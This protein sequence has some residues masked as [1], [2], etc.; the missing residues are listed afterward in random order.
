MKNKWVLIIAV[1]GITL[2][3]LFGAGVRNYAPVASD[4]AYVIEEDTELIVS[5]PGILGNDNDEDMN[6]GRDIPNWSVHPPSY[7]FNATM[8]SVLIFDG[9]E[10]VDSNDILA[11][12]VG[13]ECRGVAQPTFFPVNGRYTVNLMNYANTNGETM[14]FKAYDASEDKVYS[15]AGYSYTFTANEM[16]GNDMVPLEMN[17]F[18]MSA[19]LESDAEYGELTL[20]SDGSFNYIPIEN[21][22]GLDSFTYVAFDGIDYSN[23]ASVNITINS[24]NDAPWISTSDI[25]F[26]ED[27]ELNLSFTDFIGDVDGDQLSLSVEGNSQIS[28]IVNEFD[29]LF[30]TIT[31]NW[32]GSEDVTF[33]VSDGIDETSEIIIVNV[34][35]V[36]D[37]PVAEDD[38][39]EIDE[40]NYFQV[41]S[42]GVL[43]NDF[44]VDFLIREIPNWSVHAPN[45]E[46][47]STFTSVL[48]FDGEESAD[49]NDILAVFVG[50]E[51]RGVAQ[52]TYFPITDRFT[53][54]MMIYANTNGETMTFKAYDS[55]E[56]IV[57]SV[58]GYSY[59][60]TANDNIG[61]DMNPI[62]LNCY[63]LAVELYSDVQNGNLNLDSDGSFVYTPSLNYFGSDSFSYR[64]FD[65]TDY[66]GIASVEIVINPVN[67]APWVS[68]SDINFDEDTELNLNF[69]NL[70]G[71]VDGDQLSLSVEGNSQISIVVNEFDVLFG[72]ITENWFGSEDVTFI[73]SDGVFETTEDVVINVLPVNDAPTG[74]SDY[75]EI[76]EDIT[77]EIESPGVL[78]NDYDI[79][80]L[81]REI[82]NWSVH[83]P[84]FEFNSTFTS[85]LTFD[86]EESADENDILAVF[87]GEECRGVAQPTYFPITDRFTVNMMIYANT[88]GETMTFKAYDS[89]E[90]IVYSVGGY[91]YEFTANDNIG[92]DMNPIEL[93]CYSLSV[94]LYSDV[95]NGNLI[96]DSD[97]SFVYTPSINYF[98][99]D[100]FS[101]R[102]FDGEL[103][104]DITLASITVNPVN[105]I[106]TILLPNNFTFDEDNA[107][108]VDF[109]EFIEDADGDPLI[110][111]VLGNSNISVDIDGLYVNFGTNNQNWYGSETLTFTVN[112]NVDRTAVSD[113]VQIDVLPV[114]DA[115]NG[116][117]DFYSTNEDTEL[118]I[119]SPGVLENDYDVDLINNR[120]E[121]DWTCS[122]PDFEFNATCSSV[123]IFNGIESTDENDILAA[124][125]GDE[126]R[127]VSS[128]SYFPISGR[129]TVNMMLY[130][131]TNGETMTFKA[132]DA[133][134]DAVYNMS[135]YSV[136]FVANDIH[137]NDIDPVQFMN[138]SLLAVLDDD[139]ENGSVYLNEDG[140]FNYIPNLNYFGTDVF[141]YKVFDGELYSQST[142]V[143]IEVIPVNDLPWIALP[144]DISFD[145]D[146]SV[147][148]EFGDYV[149]DADGDEL[150]L[151]ANGFSDISVVISE[152]LVTFSTTQENWYGSEN[153]TF[154]IDDGYDIVTADVEVSVLAVNDTPVVDE[155][156]VETNEDIELAIELSGSDVDGDVLTFSVVDSPLNGMYS[157]GFYYPN[158]NYNG[159]DTFTYIANDG[160]VNSEMGIVTITVNPVNDA[161]VIN[162]PDIV[163]FEEDG[164]LN[165]DF[166]NYLSDVDGDELTL[167]VSG[168]TNLT[169]DIDG[170]NVAVNGPDNWFG[171][172]VLTFTVNDNQG[173]AIASDDVEVIVESVNDTPVLNPI[174]NLV[175]DEDVDFSIEISAT[176]IDIETNEQSLNFTVSSISEGIAEITI[177]QTDDQLAQINIDVFDNQNGIV[178]LT[179]AVIDTDGASDEEILT[180]TINS[181]NDLPFFTMESMET[182]AGVGDAVSIILEA[183]DIDSPELTFGVVN[184]PEWL[185]LNGNLLSGDAPFEGV[186]VFAVEVSD[187]EDTVFSEFVLVVLELRPV[188]TEIVDIPN[189]Q[190]GRVY[191][192]FEPAYF[193]EQL[194]T[195][196]Y[197]IERLDEEGWV[198]VMTYVAYG[199]DLYVAEVTT[200]QDATETEDAITQFRVIASL[201]EGIWISEVGEGFS[202][203]N[204]A[205]AIPTG[206]LADNEGNTVM[207]SWDASTDEDFQ[208]FSIFRD[209]EIVGYATESQFTEFD[210]SATGDISYCIT[211][212]DIHGNESENSESVVVVLT[213]QQ[214]VSQLAGWN[215]FSLNVEMEDMSLNTVLATLGSNGI[216]I[217]NQTGFAT[218]YD[219]FGWYGLNELDVMSMYMIQMSTDATLSFV[220]YPVDVTITPID[221]M[222][223]WNW[224]GYLPQQSNDLNE[225]LATIGSNGIII[226]NQTGFATYYDGFG[227]Y[228]LAIMEPGIG[229]MLEMS[230][231]AELIY[232]TPNGLVR[233]DN[234][235]IELHWSV[236][237]HQFE[238]NMTLTAVFEE[239]NEFD[240]LVAFVGD[241]VRGVSKATHFPLT[242]SYTI[243]LVI[244]GEN[245]DEV[246]FKAFQSGEVIDLTNIV[247]FEINA[248]LGN[249]FEPVLF[250]TEQKPT[251]FGLSKAYPNPFNPK[252]VIGYQLEVNSDV[253]LDVYNVQ[254]Q[255]VETLVTGQVEAGYHQVTWNA[256]N[257][258]SGLYFVRMTASDYVGTQKVLLLK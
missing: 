203:D 47:N 57:Y 152:M 167:S 119:E 199:Q 186:F 40:D 70:I 52:P 9:E 239:T 56:D 4:D 72:T 215:W 24:V 90:D 179:V 208:Y 16:S 14:T 252:T 164:N 11:A 27:T 89:S 34:L 173:R 28:I 209:G 30:G 2:S 93:N 39:F 204:I 88:N 198:G 172:E 255:L 212:T 87:V 163:T 222:A 258:P 17:C 206:L 205:P 168:N 21:F 128:P 201:E 115:P 98:G 102:V 213:V 22:N 223:G 111:T 154:N 174:G 95:Q 96:L 60:F 145:E 233:I 218:Y 242:N 182:M 133:S 1:F 112:D 224:I 216:I 58:G 147:E 180:L 140:S 241:E 103:Y 123:I 18:T 149:G 190:G 153:I 80:F 26:D 41:V 187:G 193:D 141:T 79:D 126:V 129:F 127:G 33:T 118:Y 20:N 237:P 178:E 227:W 63:S 219:G 97:G 232:P 108:F 253:R 250:K 48:T 181:I 135:G 158:E 104:S 44:D 99:S 165:V 228:G 136:T 107:L 131:N 105:D 6:P 62:E 75:Y 31:E 183:D 156:S 249:D 159:I 169:V 150:T 125:V 68:T 55:S 67:D 192:K 25:N 38:F 134:E 83:A 245:G 234:E 254:G 220:G 82:P 137:G 45:F 43:E 37:P 91:S 81:I 256:D 214:V 73:V 49:E 42:P 117:T 194:R 231:P 35:P 157:D 210:V 65:G 71:D 116:V 114:N 36:N 238:H 85:V 202:V 110:L 146:T 151:S 189:D 29:V 54:N 50:E 176:D 15:V 78:G 247:T 170:Y 200:L 3:Q 188:I 155:V 177:E 19:I 46:F 120:E 196:Y 113:N 166:T 142:A 130:A 207:L 53:V 184:Q 76:D 236:N 195:E 122:P 64:A 86:G 143:E 246:S 106:P 12:F 191:V 69:N 51:C 225:A 197:T 257:Q 109:N 74:E 162:L 185:A 94:E 66:S 226:K 248:N 84:N 59:E 244:Y 132:Y 139:A 230:E 7:E 160:E 221:L 13:A 251:T 175:T 5:A 171:T 100:T 23:I 32:F 10:S 211:S 217:K 8:T 101:Y 148:F 235:V 161:P 124:F 92:N 144:T 77:L 240:E 243:N 229:Y 61:N 121:P 138:V